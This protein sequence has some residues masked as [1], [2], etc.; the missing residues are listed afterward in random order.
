[1]G[2]W[3]GEGWAG[4]TSVGSPRSAACLLPPPPPFPP[5]FPCP[6]RPALPARSLPKDLKPHNILLTREWA[7]KI[8]DVGLARC[9]AGW[10]GTPPSHPPI[11]ALQPN[12][13]VASL[14]AAASWQ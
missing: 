7:A 9:V 12:M 14:H 13:Q 3:M 2:V 5:P 10:A 4:N 1:M 8:G 6:A 11:L